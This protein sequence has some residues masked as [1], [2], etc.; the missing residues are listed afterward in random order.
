L[1]PLAPR[2]RRRQRRDRPEVN[3]VRRQVKRQR[4][5][6]RDVLHAR[7]GRVQGSVHV[8]REVDVLPGRRVRGRD[9]RDGPRRELI[10]AESFAKQRLGALVVRVHEHPRTPPLLLGLL[11]RP[12]FRRL[13]VLHDDGERRFDGVAAV[14]RIVGDS[15]EVGAV[16]KQKR[17][18]LRVAPYKATSG[19]S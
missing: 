12:R 9:D 2:P 18:R 17:R 14:V 11:P 16:R 19:W 7:E 15:V 8:E 3:R 13:R 4:A 5:H 1:S 10:A 6:H